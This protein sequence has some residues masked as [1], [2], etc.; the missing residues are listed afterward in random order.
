[1]ELQLVRLLILALVGGGA[2][3]GVAIWQRRR[4]PAMLPLPA[5]VTLFTGPGCRLCGP[6]ADAIRRAGV[7][8]RLAEIGSLDLPGPPI[9]SL[10]V[11]VVVD[12][13][14]AVIMRRVGRAALEDATAI[15]ERSMA[16][17]A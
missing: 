5:G 11:A 1:M 15:A 7:E 6:V 8:P 12:G 2:W 13:T 9:R 10:P 4:G 16:L 17:E 3:L 14:G